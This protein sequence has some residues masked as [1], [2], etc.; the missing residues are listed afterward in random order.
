MIILFYF[1]SYFTLPPIIERLCQKRQVLFLHYCQNFNLFL[2]LCYYVPWGNFGGQTTERTLSQCNFYSFLPNLILLVHCLD[3]YRRVY[4]I[5]HNTNAM[6]ATNHK[7]SSLISLGF[8]FREVTKYIFLKPKSEG[9]FKGLLF[10]RIFFRILR[11]QENSERNNE[12][13]YFLFRLI[14]SMRKPNR[15]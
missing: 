9:K 13:I 10:S 12:V 1:C 2:T 5:D 15:L 14:Q 4:Y 11:G 7:P 6:V 8:C 3:F